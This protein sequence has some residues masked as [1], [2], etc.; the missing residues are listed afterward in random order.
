MYAC[1]LYIIYILVCDHLCDIIII[2]ILIIVIYC[3]HTHAMY[4]GI[5][6]LL[7]SVFKR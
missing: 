7:Q 6:Q 5:P 4:S 1:T 2:I 3:T